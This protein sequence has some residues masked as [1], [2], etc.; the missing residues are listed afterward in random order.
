MQWTMQ[1]DKL[2][3]NR[4]MHLSWSRWTVLPLPGLLGPCAGS[5]GC[6]EE[7]K[8][9]FL[10]LSKGW[11]GWVLWWEMGG[12]WDVLGPETCQVFCKKPQCWRYSELRLF[13]LTTARIVELRMLLWQW[14]GPGCLENSFS[15]TILVHTTF[16]WWDKQQKGNCFF[17]L[18]TA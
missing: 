12:F 10:S 11:K 2:T 14:C 3:G 13:L 1:P 5:G 6:E 8:P 17:L 4:R 9:H 16:H 15:V 18:K 7:P